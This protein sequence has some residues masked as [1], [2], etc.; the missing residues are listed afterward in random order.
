MLDKNYS[1]T[2]GKLLELKNAVQNGL[3]S[4]V[5]FAL[6]TN[7][8]HIASNLD[9]PFLY[10]CGDIV[11][12]Q[13]ATD[14][15]N[16][17]SKKEV[18][19]IPE[20]EDVLIPRQIQNLS[21]VYQHN[22][23][24]YKLHTN[25]VAGAVITLEALMQ[26][27]PSLE[28]FKEN[29]LNVTISDTL[30]LN[31]LAKKLIQMGYGRK[32]IVE[33]ET[34]FSIRG[35]ILDIFP[36]GHD[37][38]VRVEFFG[39]TIE[40]IRKFSLE[41]MLSTEELDSLTV[42]PA[43]Y[44]LVPPNELNG[45]LNKVKRAKRNVDAK[46][47]EYINAES[48][49][50]F[51]NPNSSLRS[52]FL[53]F[54]RNLFTRI[55]DY[56]PTDSV[57]IFDDT[58]LTDDKFRLY[59][60]SF[61]ARVKNLIA[62]NKLLEDH[63][64]SVLSYEETFDIPFTKLGFGKITSNVTLF[65][66]R[67]V[68]TIKSQPVP[69]YYLAL[70]EMYDDLRNFEFNGFKVRI[71]A[72]D[73]RS[74]TELQTLL[75]DNMLAININVDEDAQVGILIGDISYGFIYPSEKLVVIGYKDYLRQTVRTKS[76]L[77]KRQAFTL[78]GKG[79]YVVHEKH[80]IGISEG[81]QRVTT[82]SGAKDFYVVLYRGGDR[83]YLPADQLDTLEK[84]NGIDAPALHRIGG[85]EFER[86]KK[87]V[88]ESVKAMAI[89][90]LALYQSRF[91]QKGYVYPSDT[92]WQEEME[93]DF[94]FTETDDQL[95]AISEI[96]Q[97][98][99]KGK[100][101]DRL[102]CGDVGYGKTEVALRAVFKTCIENKQAVILAPTTILAQQHYNLI[103][104][105][106]NK[107]KFKIELLSRFVPPK[108]IKEALKRIATGESQIIVATHRVL[109]KD[110]KFNDLG[111]LVLDEEQ[112]FGVEHK[113][114]LKVY[115]NKVNILSLSAT[116]IPRTLHM[117]LSGIR[118][119]S[120]LE[121]PPKNRLPVETYVTEYNDNLLINAVSKEISR[122][123]QV[124]ILYNRVATIT[125]FYD[126]VR[127]LFDDSVNIIL[128]HGKMSEEMLEDRIRDFYDN[129]AQV[130]ISTTIIENGIDLPNANTLFVIDAD[131]LGLSQLY[132]L[133]GRVGRSNVLAYAYFT[134]REGKVLTEN[135]IKRL[136]AIMDNTELGSGFKIAMR[137]LEI[138]GAGNVLGREQH[139]QMEK[140]GYEMYLKLVQEGIDEI[141]GMVTRPKKE[142]E[143]SVD[144]TFALNEDY[145]TDNR[146]RVSFYRRISTLNSLEEARS[147]QKQLEEMYGKCTSEVINIIRISL[148]KNLA[149]K[150]NV[151]RVVIGDK[152][153]GLYF[154]SNDILTNEDTMGAISE[155]SSFAVLVPSSPP[156]IIFNGKKLTQIKRIKMVL[157]F[158]C[159]TN[160]E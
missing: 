160:V 113:E 61:I 42:L 35:D 133:R 111:L 157:E 144:G 98:M 153:V 127:S 37:A 27:Y 94:E 57:V 36:L 59:Y 106:L 58:K 8:Y 89:D 71:Y 91:Q 45:I 112:R 51:A 55:Y 66:P 88:K 69:K 43:S 136:N 74:A 125:S 129:K 40:K 9:R 30:D 110:V 132:Q 126:K 1:L 6:D 5:F 4:I 93:K 26:L 95:I 54:M 53:P 47:N 137:D 158:L 139:G 52:F 84:Y 77:H 18:I 101:M 38:P 117:A 31:E 92:V 109:S 90:L 87:R 25:K 128:A 152:G 124:F 145:I 29:T 15:L 14:I 7:R 108:N 3:D 159:R 138:R 56:L 155:F 13:R 156:A 130:L 44:I 105:R 154:Y 28:I 73:A 134:V 99:E 115:K 11:C 10:V 85:A 22:L 49:T 20:K 103:C 16:E 46:F 32:D 67:E 104:A 68:L 23:S 143:L 34:N 64:Q 140:V 60:N 83:L 151:E 96:K 12:A 147:Y 118:D 148:I 76:A 65:K 123:G 116:P 107:F 122:G 131:N 50:F 33:N 2:T 48:E 97:D 142:I 62:S 141:K 82:S 121:E 78:P 24:L 100:I 120:T 114:K 17:Y 119:I 63:T 19:L 39:D 75:R 80:G 81:I 150:L 79:D 149:Q 70:N 21:S 86:I 135:A 72:K 102:L 41:T 146:A